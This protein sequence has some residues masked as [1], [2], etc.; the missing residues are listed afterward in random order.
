MFQKL[1]QKLI[2]ENKLKSYLSYAIGEIILIVIGIMIA[3][4]INN[5]NQQRQTNSLKNG[6]YEVVMNDLQSDSAEVSSILRFYEQRKSLFDKVISKKL[7]ET[8]LKECVAC[9]YLITSR[10][11]LSV[12]QRGYL[13]LNDFQT[14]SNQRMDTLVHDLI[15]FYS[16]STDGIT[17]L[18]DFIE[19]DITHNLQFWRD[20]YSWYKTYVYNEELD[21]SSI[22]YFGKSS[23]YKNR[24][25]YHHTIVYKN[26]IPF[27][28]YFLERSTFLLRQIRKRL[29]EN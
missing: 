27:L 16:V 18:N 7:S 9:R 11:L 17:K 25:A 26:Y 21:S 20:E 24:V 5:W 2:R 19:S 29:K 12:N 6:I 4:S 22:H 15:N 23:D 14:T 8:E 3:V 13:Q 1:K 28:N 10:R